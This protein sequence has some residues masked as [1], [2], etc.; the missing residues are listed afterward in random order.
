[1][2][3]D[4]VLESWFG[5]LWRNSRKSS[6][7]EPEKAVIGILTFEVST[8]M[9]KVV[10]LWHCL[11]EKQII[12]LHED[13][14]LSPGI[15][16]LVSDDGDYLLE[17][18]L[19]EILE[20]LGSVAES[21]ARFG[22]RC[23][24][25]SYHNLDNIFD[26]FV[27]T[28]HNWLGWE[29][30]LKKME[31]KVKKLERYA[32]VSSQL[33]QELE[34]L[35]ELEQNFRRM[36]SS[37]GLNQLKLLEFQQKVLWQRQ[38]VRNL[39]EMSPWVKT[40][41]YILRLLLRALFTIVVRIKQVFGEK[42]LSSVLRSKGYETVTSDCLVR[43]HSVS[44][45]LHSSVH[46]SENKPSRLYSGPLGRS[47]SNLGLSSVKKG[48]K[49][50]LHTPYQSSILCGKPPQGKTRRLAHAG[51]FKGCMTSGSNSPV[52][53]NSMYATNFSSKPGSLFQDE[54]DKKRY[55]STVSSC[56]NSLNIKASPL[57]HRF[58]DAPLSTLGA[59]ALALHYANIIILIEKLACSPHLISLDARDDLYNMLP[60]SVRTSLSAKL[61]L[62]AKTLASSVY[63]AY[64]AAEWNLAIAKILD[65]LA[66]L[67][68]NMIKWHSERNFEKQPRYSGITVLLVQTL[69]FANQEKTEAA[70]TE[71]LM[72]LNYISRFGREFND[73]SF[74]ESS[75]STFSNDYSAYKS[76]SIPAVADHAS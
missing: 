15:Q 67:A 63:D 18:V 74:Q 48:Q 44:A 37:V 56:G 70:V 1:M 61:K 9:S 65:W 4:T 36:H 42:Q 16:K 40:Y 60:S 30:G 28:G 13:I 26:D 75:C 32:A 8:L 58:L 12:R 76:N 53:Q 11:S 35:A 52:M 54:M 43:S 10:N 72:G 14:F 17:L 46:P 57:K 55:T 3:G 6:V 41:D 20:S 45:H 49:N 51:P 66:P 23:V 39:R 31:K 73:I 50:K 5:N 29:Y 19:A 34:V 25:S 7:M 59:A 69:Y 47:I 22:K 27:N 24:D 71:L 21:V 33:F 2:K 64:L 38:E 68:H 62:F